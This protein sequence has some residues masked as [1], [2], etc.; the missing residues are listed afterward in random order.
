MLYAQ[1]GE[2]N[3]GRFSLR[4]GHLKLRSVTFEVNHPLSVHLSHQATCQ[5]RAGPTGRS[6]CSTMYSTVDEEKLFFVQPRT[7]LLHSRK[8]GY[9]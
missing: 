6:S 4:Q 9:M 5:G 1:G 3:T 8:R 7:S 2:T